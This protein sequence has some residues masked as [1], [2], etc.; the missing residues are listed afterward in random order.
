MLA[1]FSQIGK[2]QAPLRIGLNHQEQGLLSTK[3]VLS[4]SV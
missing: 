4:G 3:Q 1:I 2:G